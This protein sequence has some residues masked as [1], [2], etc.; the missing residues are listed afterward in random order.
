MSALAN[1]V[2]ERSTSST[3]ERSDEAAP[4]PSPRLAVV[5]TA[6]NGTSRRNQERTNATRATGIAARKTGCR[7][8]ENACCTPSLTAAGSL[9][10]RA[11]LAGAPVAL[12]PPGRVTP[13][14]AEASSMASRFEKIA[15]KI[16]TPNAPPMLRK[17]VT[18]EVAVPRSA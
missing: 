2:S 7:A 4:R 15:P 16:D 17:K 14:S 13:C 5:V 9:F 10:S 1:R 18:P 3:E 8:S 12:R 11:G 6:R